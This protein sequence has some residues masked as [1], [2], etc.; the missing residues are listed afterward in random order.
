MKLLA[1]IREQIQHEQQKISNEFARL[2]GFKSIHDTTT[3]IPREA[4]QKAV[5]WLKKHRSEI[6]D[7]F[8][9][10]ATKKLRQLD[11]EYPDADVI[12]CFRQMVRCARCRLISRKM[13]TWNSS[14]KSQSYVLEYKI[15]SDGD[16]TESTNKKP[17]PQRP[18]P[19][20]N[21]PVTNTTSPTPQK[22]THEHITT[23]ETPPTPKKHKT[24]H[25]TQQDTVNDV[26]QEVVHTV[27]VEHQQQTPPVP[28][29][30]PVQQQTQPD[31]QVVNT[32]VVDTQVVK[33]Q[34]VDT[35][36]TNTQVVQSSPPAQP[37]AKTPPVSPLQLNSAP[38]SPT[39]AD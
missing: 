16:P 14:N 13:Y 22:R 10:E 37:L 33:T 38:N 2:L 25:Q 11:N 28:N 17:P 30:T 12:T 4:A 9:R 18:T 39:A 32:Q 5:E 1:K 23:Q 35:Q 24:Q 6:E 19:V 34:V 7:N 29:N 31:T 26:L 15:L 3:V 36:Q 8:P 21:N 20:Q 27:A